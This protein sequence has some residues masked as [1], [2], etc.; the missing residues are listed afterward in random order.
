MDDESTLNINI[1]KTKYRTH[2]KTVQVHSIKIHLCTK[3][4]EICSCEEIE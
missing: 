4:I 3:N 1:T 2:K